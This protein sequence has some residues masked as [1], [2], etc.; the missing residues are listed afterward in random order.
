M[1]KLQLIESH[2]L[3]IL[4][5]A[6]ESLSLSNDQMC[7]LN[8]CWNSVYRK[9]FSYHKWESVRVLICT[10][11]RLDLHHIVNLRR[12]SFIKRMS[13]N[14]V[15][16]NVISNVMYYYVDRAECTSVIKCFNS[17]LHWSLNKFKAMMYVS[18][19]AEVIV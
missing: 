6:I 19:R 8:S 12:L 13:L 11:G 18:F 5:Y 10:L 16:N 17:Q 3:P 14:E 9:I 15:N 4:L 1:V 2:C 7:E